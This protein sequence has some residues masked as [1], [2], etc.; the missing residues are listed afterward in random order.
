VSYEQIRFAETYWDT[1]AE[2]YVRDFTGTGIGETRRRAVWRRLEKIFSPGQKLLELNC[3]TGIDAVHLAEMGMQLVACDIS[4]RMIEQARQLAASTNTN[5]FIDFKVL[6]NEEIGSIEGENA[7]DG[8][9]SNFCGLNCV[10]DL[11]AVARELTRLVRPGAPLLL[12]MMGH[13]VPW[14]ILW[15]LARGEPEKALRR[16]RGN[17]FHSA[18]PGGVCIQRPSVKEMTR[19]MSPGFKLRRWSG[20]GIAVPPTYMEKRTRNFPGVIRALAG[21]DRMINDLPVFRRMG[22]CVLLEFECVKPLEGGYE[23][24]ACGCGCTAAGSSG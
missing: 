17:D 5:R 20:V 11:A 24:S 6:A 7:F 22:D 18:E 9:F 23:C 14:E 4:P 8:A 2:T 15:F 3:G 19:I 12:C 21:I 1:A 16:L 10:Q 13:F